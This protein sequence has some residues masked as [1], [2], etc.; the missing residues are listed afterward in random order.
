[1]R[2][3]L[4]HVHVFP[5][6]L[7]DLVQLLTV[8]IAVDEDFKLRVSSFGFSGLNVHKVDVVFLLIYN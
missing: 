6:Q 1:M 5:Q 4:E 3:H 2:V 7:N 8:A